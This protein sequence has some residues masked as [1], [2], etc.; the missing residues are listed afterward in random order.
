M[1]I[2]D[3][4]ISRIPRRKL[5]C[6]AHSS[7]TKEPCKKW[8]MNGRSVCSIH[9][10]KTP[11][12]RASPHYKHG[13]Y[14]KDLPTRLAGRYFEALEDDNLLSLRDEIAVVDSFIADLMSNLGAGTSEEAWKELHT[15]AFISQDIDEVQRLLSQARSDMECMREL[16]AQIDRA[17]ALRDSESK[18]LIQMDMMISQE[19][20]NMMLGVIVGIVMQALQSHVQDEL[21]RRTIYAEISQGFSVRLGSD[22]DSIPKRI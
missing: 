12:G 5:K 1:A 9:G 2:S 13:R 11:R 4:S 20:A 7:C 17:R 19:Q 22:P 21:L 8:A 16:G 3:P 6:H 14:S 15:A 18:R 10:G